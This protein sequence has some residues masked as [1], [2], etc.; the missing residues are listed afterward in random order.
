VKDA[1][2]RKEGADW[3][4]RANR[5]QVKGIG[6]AIESI[7]LSLVGQTSRSIGRERWDDNGCEASKKDYGLFCSLCPR[8]LSIQLV[9]TRQKSS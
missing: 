1:E 6:M 9:W 5:G 3:R 8:I 2:S 4:A 7:E